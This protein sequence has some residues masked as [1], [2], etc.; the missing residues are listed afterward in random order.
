MGLSIKEQRAKIRAD[1]VLKGEFV[2]VPVIT[3]KKHKKKKAK[4]IKSK[5][6]TKSI[7]RKRIIKP[8]SAHKQKYHDYLLSPEWAQIKI[9]LF[10][11]RGKKCERCPSKYNL[12]VHHL[13]YNNIFNEEPEDLIILCNKC[14][15]LEH[16]KK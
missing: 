8:L 5:V 16:K 13:H 7:K 9:D 6:K 1:K 14:H 12:H 11:H 4:R 10:E 3:P 15:S 2:S